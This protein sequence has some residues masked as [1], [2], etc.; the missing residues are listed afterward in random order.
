[1]CPFL[2]PP[3]LFQNVPYYPSAAEK[4]RA[5][6]TDDNLSFRFPVRLEEGNRMRI[7]V[8]WSTPLHPHKS[9]EGLRCCT[10]GGSSFTIKAAS[11]LCDK[12]MPKDCRRFFF[13]CC[14]MS[15]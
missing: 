4:K 9:S 6:I 15:L 1:M 7:P 8:S 11:P 5:Q 3:A 12:C 13:S 14:V 10:P 2:H